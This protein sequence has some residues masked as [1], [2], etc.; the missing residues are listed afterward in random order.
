MHAILIFKTIFKKATT[1]YECAYV[2]YGV[3]CYFV[4]ERGRLT[5]YFDRSINLFSCTHKFELNYDDKLGCCLKRALIVGFSECIME[6]LK[7]LVQNADK[8][9]A[10]R[11][12]NHVY[13]LRRLA[14]LSILVKTPSYR[15]NVRYICHRLMRSVCSCPCCSCFRFAVLAG[16]Y[17][18]V[19]RIVTLSYITCYLIYMNIT[20]DS[21]QQIGFKRDLTDIRHDFDC[22]LLRYL[23]RD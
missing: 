10:W 8:L 1:S 6:S 16:F 5:F 11:R 15:L 4:K 9:R 14:I 22:I 23:T 19:K 17:V 7:K 20:K 18:K 13:D 21:C 2:L 12:M 3:L